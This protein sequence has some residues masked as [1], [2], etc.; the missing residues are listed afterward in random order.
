[1]A[2]VISS[3]NLKTTKFY[4]GEFELEETVVPII[5]NT[6]FVL[7]LRRAAGPNPENAIPD[8]NVRSIFLFII[9]V[10]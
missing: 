7:M 5:D 8:I 1:M 2:I 9:L 6:N 3:L 10:I 4:G